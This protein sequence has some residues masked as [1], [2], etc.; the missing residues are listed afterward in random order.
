MK[1]GCYEQIQH[2]KCLNYL[3]ATFIVCSIIPCVQYTR[4]FHAFS[5]KSVMKALSS[6]SVSKMLTGSVYFIFCNLFLRKYDTL[7]NVALRGSC[8]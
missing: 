7:L 5:E 8:G 4:S 6:Y 2:N 1:G 3:F